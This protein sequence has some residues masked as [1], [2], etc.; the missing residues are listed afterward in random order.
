VE[1]SPD[2]QYQTVQEAEFPSAEVDCKFRRTPCG[3]QA[4]KVRGT[5]YPLPHLPVA[6]PM[7]CKSNLQ[8]HPGSHLASAVEVLHLLERNHLRHYSCSLLQ[9]N[10][11]FVKFYD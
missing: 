8:I 9:T 7:A 6:P 4:A 3:L 5:L 11:N 2:L 1:T 10:S